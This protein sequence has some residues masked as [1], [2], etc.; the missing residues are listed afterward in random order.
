ML[1]V[2]N[3][4]INGCGKIPSVRSNMDV[5]SDALQNEIESA[6]ADLASRYGG[7]LALILDPVLTA[8][9]RNGRFD[10][11][12]AEHLGNL[13]QY[14]QRMADCYEHLHHYIEKLQVE[15]DNLVWVPLYSKISHWIFTIFLHKEFAKEY[16][17]NEIVPELAQEAVIQLLNAQF[18]YDTDFDPWAYMIVR[19]TCFKYMRTSMKKTAVPADVLVALD[20]TIENRIED[21]RL[22][23]DDRYKENRAA[24]LAAINRLSP[25]RREVIIQKYFYE[26][27]SDKIAENTH[28]TVAAIY[29]MHFNAIENLRKILSD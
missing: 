27:P 13:S 6:L 29:S 26:L 15:K 1:L 7:E 21:P 9:I 8:N 10:T 24:L 16:I 19:A 23:P 14:V 5:H 22:R 3:S 2:V 12:C 4:I 18:T 17:F 11:F 25:E 20:E 28:K